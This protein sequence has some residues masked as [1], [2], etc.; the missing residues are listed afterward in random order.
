VAIEKCSGIAKGIVSSNDILES[1]REDKELE[2][3][4]WRRLDGEGSKK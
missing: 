4:K 2:E 3:A 1:R